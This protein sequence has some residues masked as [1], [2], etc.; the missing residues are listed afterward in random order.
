MNKFKKLWDS[1]A[2]KPETE[3]TV[4]TNNSVD[5][6]KELRDAIVKYFLQHFLSQKNFTD[7]IVVWISDIRQEYQ[8]YIRNDGI[9]FK[10]DL[11]V[12]LDNR[13]LY[14]ISKASIEFKL[15]NPP[16]EFTKIS[17]GVYIQLLAEKE[18]IPQEI[19]TK[20]RITVLKDKGSLMR[21][22]YLLDASK[23]LEFNI[24]RGDGN[25]N[26]IIIKENDPVNS[27][28][29]NRVSRQHA[30]IIFVTGKGFCLQSRNETNRTIINR[31]NRRF[32][33]LTDLNKKTLLQ[34]NDEIELGK[35]VCLRFEIVEKA[36][37]NNQAKSAFEENDMGI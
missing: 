14:A 18:V 8:N 2:G 34:S 13:Q 28:I 35:S 25:N 15:E 29:N 5:A 27:E 6:K 9:E 10:N 19:F 31:N 32:D 7:T 30:K 22:E 37:A 21:I 4:T 16:Q 23:Q 20:A 3:K 12:E 11:C 26:H 24:G 33:D 1:L 17:E 36:T